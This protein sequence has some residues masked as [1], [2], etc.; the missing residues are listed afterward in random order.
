MPNLYTINFTFYAQKDNQSG[1]V[2]HIIANTDEQ[3]YEWLKSEP[4]LDETKTPFYGRLYN[5]Y[6]YREAEE[7][8]FKQRIIGCQGD[9]YDEQSEVG[10]LYY[11]ATQLGWEFVKN[12]SEQVVDILKNAI[13]VIDIRED[14]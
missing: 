13:Y 6:K 8:E 14:K 1:I 3:I 10:D 5:N 12:V 7:D 9:M 11:G 2:T 4:K